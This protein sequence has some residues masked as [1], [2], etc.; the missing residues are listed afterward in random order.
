MVPTGV[1]TLGL[2]C[3]SSIEHFSQYVDREVRILA[4]HAHDIYKAFEGG[5]LDHLLH[6]LRSNDVQ[7]YVDAFTIRHLEDFVRPVRMLGVVD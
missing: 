7:D 1:S 2:T 4:Q 6:A 5:C 3:L